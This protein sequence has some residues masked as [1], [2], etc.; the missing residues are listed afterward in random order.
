MSL[1]DESM[2]FLISCNIGLLAVSWVVALGG[3]SSMQASCT[4]LQP[5][6]AANIAVSCSSVFAYKWVTASCFSR[7]LTLF[8]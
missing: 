5:K 4:D 1:S 6:E 8:S 3:Y 2:Q 7:A